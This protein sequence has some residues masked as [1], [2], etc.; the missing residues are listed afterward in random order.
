MSKQEFGVSIY[1]T[2]PL[3]VGDVVEVT[4]TSSRSGSNYLNFFIQTMEDMQYRMT[5]AY[6]TSTPQ[7]LTL[8]ANTASTNWRVGL[9]KTDSTSSSIYGTVYIHDIKVNGVKIL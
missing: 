1:T 4:Y 5:G 7:K 9:D 2:Y 3:K 8:T 6:T